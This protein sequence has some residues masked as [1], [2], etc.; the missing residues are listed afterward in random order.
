MVGPL[1]RPVGLIELF[2][3]RAQ[4]VLLG[5]GREWLCQGLRVAQN[6]CCGST[7]RQHLCTGG[8]QQTGGEGTLVKLL[9][10]ACIQ[11]PPQL[12]F[13]EMRGGASI[14]AQRLLMNT[15]DKTSQDQ[16]GVQG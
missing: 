1:R 3:R 7:P 11:T 12:G 8:V 9:E 2:L 16:K 5:L 4:P 6:T 15:N 10:P 13:P 14:S